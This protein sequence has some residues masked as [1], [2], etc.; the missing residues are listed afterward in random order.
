MEWT[1]SDEQLL[2]QRTAREFAA[3]EV[4]PRARGLDREGTW[5]ADLVRRLGELGL[6]G[7]AV[8][9]EYGGA[10]ADNVSYALAIEEIS[11]ACASVGVIMSVNNSLV[12]DPLLKFGS[13][14]QKRRFL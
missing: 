8:P 3:R 9:I 2:V 13:E 5:P 14:D 4:E 11:A 6:M 12:C 10:G 1:L 7:V